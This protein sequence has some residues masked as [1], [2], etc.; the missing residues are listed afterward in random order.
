MSLKAK[1]SAVI[2][3]LKA[4]EEAPDDNCGAEFKA[5]EE[6]ELELTNYLAPNRSPFSG[7][8]FIP[9]EAIKTI[10]REL[11][12]NGVEGENEDKE[13]DRDQASDQ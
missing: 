6:R 8:W 1:I 3:A 13:D 2:E 12:E 5:L 11:F 10:W 9:E 4:Y 7:R